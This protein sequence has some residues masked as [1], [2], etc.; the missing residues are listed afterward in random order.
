[1]E[2]LH[3]DQRIQQ[4]I[5]TVNHLLKGDSQTRARDLSARNFAVIPLGDNFGM[6]RWIEG[7]TGLFSIFRKWQQREH[8]ALVLQRKEG[9]PDIPPPVRPHDA[10]AAKAS[11][12][13]ASRGVKGGPSRKNWPTGMLKEIFTELKRETPNNLIS[14]EL[15]SSS[16]SSLTWWKKTKTFSRSAAVMSIVG[17]VIGLGDRHL[18]N[19]LIDVEHG[20]VA[21]I[22]FNVCFEKGRNLRIPETV[23]FRL[24]QNIVGALGPNDIEGTFRIACEQ[25]F[26]VMRENREILLTLLEAFIYDPLVDWT[27]NTRSQHEKSLMNLNAQIGY[28]HRVSLNSRLRY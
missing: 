10:F 25:V 1:M 4:F 3:L 15:W 23:P 14:M 21:H 19:I 22:D 16:N 6:I 24:T 28:C 7:A 17:Y 20:E 12:A 2:D 13:L 5:V 27:H 8:A 18:D 11:K 26:R 9:A